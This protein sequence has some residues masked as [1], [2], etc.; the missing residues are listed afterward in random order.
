MIFYIMRGVVQ[1]IWPMKGYVQVG[2]WE[3]CCERIGADPGETERA[4]RRLV[5]EKY[6]LDGGKSTTICG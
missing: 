3:M 4:R 5:A 1:V 6:N 2:V